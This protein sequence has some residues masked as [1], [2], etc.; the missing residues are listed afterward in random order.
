MTTLS[1]SIPVVIDLRQDS[2]TQ[3]D[4]LRFLLYLIENKHLT[5]GDVL[6]CDN[7]SVHVADETTDVI[8]DLL[9]AYSIC[10]LF[11]PAYSPELNP[12]ELVFSFLK[13]TLRATPLTPALHLDILRALAKVTSCKVAAWYSHCIW[14]G[15]RK[16]LAA[17]KNSK[18]VV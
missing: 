14:P 5:A 13:Q 3:F 12:C 8:L 10:L 15:A 9:D 7:A 4:F 16:Q 1:S 11:L 18:S 17:A 6:V 2:N